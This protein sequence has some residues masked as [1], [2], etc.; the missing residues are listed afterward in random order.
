MEKVY[1]QILADEDCL[2]MKDLQI[3]GKDL[4]KMGV[5]QGQKIGEILKAIFAEVVDDPALN[6]RDY[7]LNKVKDMLQ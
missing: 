1:H 2:S 6:N 3:S 7:L 4:I 5:P